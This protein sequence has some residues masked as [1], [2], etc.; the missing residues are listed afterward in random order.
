MSS[1]SCATVQKCWPFG[2]GAVLLFHRPAACPG[3]HWHG[4][5][6]WMLAQNPLNMAS[7]S[8][9][10]HEAIEAY[11]NATPS[12]FQSAQ[13]GIDKIA[14]SSD[15]T[16]VVEAC[17]SLLKNLPQAG[18]SQAASSASSFVCTQVSTTRNTFVSQPRFCFVQLLCTLLKRGHSLS[19]P[20]LDVRQHHNSSNDTAANCTLAGNCR[21]VMVAMQSFR[22]QLVRL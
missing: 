21:A 2:I 18:T 20:G 5:V 9:Q 4:S 11:V 12:T 22:C 16:P 13:L 15:G 17:V 7:I 3:T 8:R 10:L 1:V 6:K 19:E 14:S